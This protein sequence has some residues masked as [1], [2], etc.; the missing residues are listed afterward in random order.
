MLLH[1]VDIETSHLDP[2]QGEIT[3]IAIITYD[4]K[5]KDVLTFVEKIKLEKPENAD[6]KS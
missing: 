4:L 6:Q 3:E 5:T 2:N 1:F